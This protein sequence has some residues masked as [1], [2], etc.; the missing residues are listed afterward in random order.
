MCRQWW[1][2]V[3]PEAAVPVIKKKEEKKV[4]K[5]IENLSFKLINDYRMKM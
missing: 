3:G 4:E 1:I 5:P 2:W